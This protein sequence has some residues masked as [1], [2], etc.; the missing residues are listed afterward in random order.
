MWKPPVNHCFRTSGLPMKPQDFSYQQK[1]VNVTIQRIVR[2]ISNPADSKVNNLQP[3][4]AIIQNPDCTP[5]LSKVKGNVLCQYNRA[6]DQ[7]YQFTMVCLCE[8]K[9]QES[10]DPKSVVVRQRLGYGGMNEWKWCVRNTQLNWNTRSHAL[11]FKVRQ[12]SI[13]GTNLSV[14]SQFLISSFRTHGPSVFRFLV[15]FVHS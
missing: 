1:S 8:W 6:T 15:L 9:H 13:W 10:V 11:L 7:I 12:S 3:S 14:W 2:S 5:A 4:N